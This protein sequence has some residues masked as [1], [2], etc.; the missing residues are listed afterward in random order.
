MSPRSG[1][2]VSTSSATAKRPGDD[3][4]DTHR[5][6]AADEPEEVEADGQLGPSI[7]QLRADDEVRHEPDGDRPEDADGD[8]PPDEPAQQ[9]D[10]GQPDGGHSRAGHGD[11][12]E[13]GNQTR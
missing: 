4:D 9:V 13:D 2:I 3:A 1:S 5:E 8:R 12:L 6:D 10:A 11:E 7:R